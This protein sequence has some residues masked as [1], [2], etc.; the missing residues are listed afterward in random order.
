MGLGKLNASTEGESAAHRPVRWAAGLVALSFLLSYY[1]AARRPIS[2]DEMSTADLG[3]LSLFGWLG[4][5]LLANDGMND[6]ARL[7]GLLRRIVTAGGL[8]GVLGLVQFASGHS[9]VE[10][11]Q[12]PGLTSNTPALAVPPSAT[13]STVRPLQ[14]S[15]PSS[16]AW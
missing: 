5:V 16:S 2:P 10:A 12:I 13:V 1:V 8:L 9:F 15:M 4:I 14:R 11:I 3:L 7:R 6:P